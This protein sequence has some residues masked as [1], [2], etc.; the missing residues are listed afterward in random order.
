MK[1]LPFI[2][3]TALL[4]VAC[5]GSEQNSS[6]NLDTETT[7]RGKTESVVLN[8]SSQQELVS[9][10]FGSF[11]GEFE[12]KDQSQN[13]FEKLGMRF[14]LKKTQTMIQKLT[15]DTTQNQSYFSPSFNGLFGGK[16]EYS[17]NRN[18]DSV[19]IVFNFENF[20][21]DGHNSWSDSVLV[22]FSKNVS[23]IE[24]TQIGFERLKVVTAGNT[25]VITGTMKSLYD[26][27]SEA[28]E[29]NWNIHIEDGTAE[30]KLEN[31]TEEGFKSSQDYTRSTFQGSFYHSDYGKLEFVT[32]SA[33]EC[34]GRT[35][36]YGGSILLE[37]LHGSKIKITP[38]GFGLLH[39]ELDADG[40][41]VYESILSQSHSEVD[42]Y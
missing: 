34:Y 16:V 23:G 3:I 42:V 18:D 11:R 10:I 19:Q 7:Y 29:E 32:T 36:C 27:S 22:E 9:L 39:F 1:G 6:V 8:K 24:E 30:I 2:L 38:E 26:P 14:F 31:Y 28:F 12:P 41:T 25:Y 35:P 13:D 4:A 33:I 21:P 40:D 5:G 15:Q 37:G 20:S 17:E